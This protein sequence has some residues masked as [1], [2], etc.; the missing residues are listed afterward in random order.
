M[1]IFIINKSIIH[2]FQSCRKE[3]VKNNDHNLP[4]AKADILKLLALS[5]YVTVR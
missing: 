4:R 2:C 1:I 5:T 3:I